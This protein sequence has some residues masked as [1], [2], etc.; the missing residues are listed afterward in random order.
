MRIV[1]IRTPKCAESALSCISPNVAPLVDSLLPAVSAALPDA[2]AAAATAAMSAVEHCDADP[3]VPNN[4]RPT[5]LVS[6]FQR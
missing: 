2:A 6:N 4:K 5:R 1:N 3:P